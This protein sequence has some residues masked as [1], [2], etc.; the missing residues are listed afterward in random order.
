LA[1]RSPR[2]LRPRFQRVGLDLTEVEHLD[3]YGFFVIHGLRQR[4]Q[5]RQTTL[6]LLIPRDARIRR[7]VELLRIHDFI[8]VKEE[9]ED[10][11]HTLG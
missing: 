3:S 10:A 8:P 6:V 5:E 7:A 11:L 1:S 9:L 2:P 4:L